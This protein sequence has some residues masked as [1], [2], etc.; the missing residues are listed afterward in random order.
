MQKFIITS[1]IALFSLAAMAQDRKVAVFDPV[2][3]ADHNIRD[4]VRELISSAVVNTNGYVVLERQLIDRVLE[5]NRFQAGGMVDD[6]QVVEMGRLMGANLAFVSTVADLG[7]NYFISGKMIDVQ[8][9][10][11]EMQRT[12]QTQRGASDLMTVVLNM[13]GEM[14]GQPVAETATPTETPIQTPVPTQTPAPTQPTTIAPAVELRTMPAGMLFSK[15][16]KVYQLDRE[17]SESDFRK[18]RKLLY[19]ELGALPRNDV[20]SL[21]ANTLALQM[22][23]KSYKRNRIGNILVIGGTVVAAAGGVIW[24]TQP[25]S[26][27]D[28]YAYRGFDMV[29]E[30]GFD[31][32]ERNRRSQYYSF[33]KS[34]NKDIVIATVA[35]GA[36]MVITGILLKTASCSVPVYKSVNM[37]NKGLSNQTNMEL[38][39]GFTGNGVHLTLNF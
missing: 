1:I 23:N 25:F 6:T 34:I 39:F 26:K 17:M 3:S 7:I 22:Y 33:R 21:M 24:V 30:L 11:I 27:P 28:Y 35:P 20:Q 15:G 4:I 16:K 8:T 13:V 38:D 19:Q 32:D 29:F 5:E 18:Y 10:R 37:Y 2:G 31:S 14:L 36:A 9:A 12:A